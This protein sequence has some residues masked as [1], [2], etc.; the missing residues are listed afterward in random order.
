[1]VLI[2]R[3]PIHREKHRT[4]VSRP[5]DLGE[6]NRRKDSISLQFNKLMPKVALL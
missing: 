4:V 3:I 5:L 2:L 6:R 1:M